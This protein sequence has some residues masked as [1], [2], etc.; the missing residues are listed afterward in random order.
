MEDLAPSAEDLFGDASM[1]DSL[2]DGDDIL[3]PMFGSYSGS[4][5]LAPELGGVDGALDDHD[6][7]LAALLALDDS[8]IGDDIPM[9]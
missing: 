7:M 4:L 9:V 8:L 1:F 6:P 3:D 5:T 2:M